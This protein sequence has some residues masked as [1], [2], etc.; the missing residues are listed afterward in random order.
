MPQPTTATTRVLFEA[1]TNQGAAEQAVARCRTHAR[2]LR[3]WV[4]GWSRQLSRAEQAV[5]WQ[6]IMTVRATRAS[7]LAEEHALSVSQ[8]LHIEQRLRTN[9]RDAL[10][11]RALTSSRQEEQLGRWA[12]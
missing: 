9:L 8:V 1:A 10:A 6:R 7:R 3:A 5:L 4:H 11:E 2:A 12:S